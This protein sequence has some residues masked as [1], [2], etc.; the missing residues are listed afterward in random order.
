MNELIKDQ[1]LE[2]VNDVLELE[3]GE[4]RGDADFEEEYE[5]DSLRKIEI[6]ARIEKEIK[7][8]I[9]QSELENFNS[10]NSVYETVKKHSGVNI[11]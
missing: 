8:Q 5:A 2:I 10:L 4:I 3:E 9:P 7:I 6:L 1:V 11:S